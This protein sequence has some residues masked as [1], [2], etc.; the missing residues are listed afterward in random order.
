MYI[1][2]LSSNRKLYS[3]KRL[4]EEASKK[5]HKVE[6]IDPLRCYIDVSSK[7]PAV[8]YKKRKLNNVDFVIPRI[9]ASSNAFGIAIVR[10]FE[11]MG[12]KVMNTA[13]AIKLSRDKL[14]SLQVLSKE[15][16]PLP[17][18]G[19]ADCTKQ[20]T[21]LLKIVGGSPIVVK[22]IESSQGK[23]VVLAETDSASKSIIDAFR[24][25]DA[26]FLVQEFIKEADGKDV[27]CF[28]LNGEIVATMERSAKAGDFRSNLHRGGTARSITL[29]P[30]EEKIAI[31]AS[32]A[33]GLNLAGVDLIQSSE[34]YK[35][36]EVNSSPGLEGIENYSGKNVAE[37][38][39][40]F[41][42]NN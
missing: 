33:L 15:K 41:I 5:G 35:V 26:N 24:E 42:E 12:V 13:N 38:I 1:V 27:R 17:R 18:T 21:D 9:G 2:I 19:F 3:S 34:G 22:L 39:I 36:L 10:Q 40:E 28:V 30:E 37:K 4:F 29:S 23:G 11:M 25:L 16:I 31:D 32:M 6:I 8:Y 7:A 20:T 14:G